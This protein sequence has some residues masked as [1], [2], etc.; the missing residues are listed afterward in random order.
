MW[1]TC[2]NFWSNF[3]LEI[4]W[5]GSLGPVNT[6]TADGH[7]TINEHWHSLHLNDF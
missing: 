4:K 5:S 2:G 6:P 1:D 3:L 7:Y